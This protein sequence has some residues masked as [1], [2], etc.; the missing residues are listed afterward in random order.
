MRMRIPIVLLLCAFRLQAASGTNEVKLAL[1][2]TYSMN[3]DSNPTTGYAWKLAS[4]TNQV[5]TLVTNYYEPR[6]NGKRL[7]GSGGVE[8]WTFK[9]I[10]KGR[11]ELVL[12]YARPWEKAAIKKTNVVIV[13]Q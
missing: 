7:V 13:C 8:H 12:E 11:A 1:G 3:L 9:A 2:Q 4:P 6:K 5:F 10:Q